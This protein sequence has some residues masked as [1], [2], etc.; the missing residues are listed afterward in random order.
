MSK[1]INQYRKY[2]R[3]GFGSLSISIL[4]YK[5]L[6]GEY[7]Q[8]HYLTR[9]NYELMEKIK[10]YNKRGSALDDMSQTDR[11]MV[12]RL[13]KQRER[14][15]RIEAK[16][17]GKLEQY[18]KIK[19]ALLRQYVEKKE[20]GKMR[21]DLENWEY[22]ALIDLIDYLSDIFDKDG[23]RAAAIKFKAVARVRKWA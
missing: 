12:I 9:R 8:G 4:E 3:G 13:L 23:E 5:T 2:M 16:N 1:A 19:G 6:L 20:R 21:D 10:R 14:L 15:A 22:L 18:R 17:D 7:I 11:A